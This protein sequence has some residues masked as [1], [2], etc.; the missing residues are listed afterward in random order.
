MTEQEEQSVVVSKTRDSHASNATATSTSAN[1]LGAGDGERPPMGYFCAEHVFSM[2]GVERSL[3][4][5]Y[6][7][8]ACQITNE[9]YKSRIALLLSS[10]STDVG[11]ILD[12]E[13]IVQAGG[14]TSQM[15]ACTSAWLDLDTADLLSAR[16]FTQVLA[17]EISYASFCGIAGVIVTGPRRRNNLAQFAQ[18]INAALSISSYVQISIRLPLAEDSP[19]GSKKVFSGD[20]LSTWEVWN[21]IRSMCGNHPRLSVALGVPTLL[22]GEVCSSRW[23]AEPVRLLVL[24]AHTFT[25]N[26]KDWPVLYK[27]QQ[28]FFLHFMKQKPVVMLQETRNVNCT[29]GPPS[30]HA[31][32]RH[33]QSRV[34]GPGATEKFGNG[35]QDYLQSPLQPLTDNLESVTYEVFEEDPVK[36]K[37]YELA[38]TKAMEAR[39]EKNITLAVVGAGRGPLVACALRAGEETKK[40][41][42]IYALEKNPNAYVHLLRRNREE[43]GNMVTVAKGDMRHWQPKKYVD[44]LVSELLGSFADNELSPEC[45]DGVQRVLNPKGGIMIPESYSN[46]LTP[47]MSSKL[48]VDICGREDQALFETPFVVLLQAFDNLSLAQRPK[49]WE[50]RHPCLRTRDD[51]MH[52]VRRSKRTFKVPHRGVMHGVAGYFEAVLFGDV[53]LS[54]NPDS[55]DEK[56]PDMIS[57]FPI[58]FP[59]KVGL[60]MA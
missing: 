58:F 42:F 32:I 27:A 41:L 36:Y 1:G 43:W 17:Q 33:L 57:W 56:S 21:V 7:Y 14:M 50:F 11:T 48:Y 39:S 18:A 55:M 44:I 15:I 26:S 45:C 10:G 3:N 34:P 37:Q 2:D 5:G 31:Y 52:N 8:A 16:V 54:T 23:F 24:S 9:A 59:F 49:M 53:E 51:N 20:A 60:V 38:M 47:V 29:G 40:Q 28:A 6:E 25:R 22:A 12:H 4:E 46:Y 35:Y 19:D 30:F 13:V